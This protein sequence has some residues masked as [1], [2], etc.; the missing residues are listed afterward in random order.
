MRIPLKI[1][2]E[3]TDTGV[4]RGTVS[5]EGADP[6]GF[7]VSISDLHKGTTQLVVLEFPEPKPPGA[8]PPTERMRKRARKSELQIAEDIG[9]KA[10]KNSG[11]LPWAKGD[12]RLR[13]KHRIESKTTRTKSYH[14]TRQELNKIRSECGFGEKPSFVIVFINPA[15]FREDDKWVLQPYADWYEANV[16]SGPGSPG[17]S[18][19]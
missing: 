15:T 13:G 1:D 6:E 3:L 9:G 8:Q 18:G 12:V 7:N 10:Q 14:V 4:L 16:D 5:A 11:A 19:S 2:L 17:S